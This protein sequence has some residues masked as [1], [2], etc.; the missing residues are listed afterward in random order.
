[1]KIIFIGFRL[2]PGLKEA[3][4]NKTFF[5]SRQLIKDKNKVIIITNGDKDKH[6]NFKG[7]KIHVCGCGTRNSVFWKNRNQFIEFATQILIKEQPDII[8]DVFGML[9]TSTITQKIIKKSKLK[10]TS[11]VRTIGAHGFA[12]K[13]FGR[14]PE[15]ILNKGFVQEYLPSLIFDNRLI[16]QLIAKKY[17]NII[18]LSNH[19]AKEFKHKSKLEI[20]NSIEL[21]S[22]L[23]YKK[24]NNNKIRKF[25]KENKLENKDIILYLGHL[26]FQKG[27]KYIIK[28]LPSILK[29]NKNAVVIFA[30]SGLG[31]D[32]SKYIKMFR[33][34][35]VPSEKVKIIEKVDPRLAFSASKIFILPLSFQ[36]GTQAQPDSLIEALACGCVP[37]VSGIGS[38]PE[39]VKNKKNGLLIKPFSSEEI[40][41]SV[42]VLLSNDKFYKKLQNN[43]KKGLERFDWKKNFPKHKKNYYDLLS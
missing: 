33:R 43:T 26:K 14:L 40:S 24:K 27:V 20:N 16:R 5:I 3:I 9:G 10:R 25:L 4:R 22:F 37:I 12:T 29:K 19:I 31:E 41:E 32:K 6:V 13:D 23:D 30:L 7:I 2:E 11:T 21:D 34:M 15:A 17:D 39:V 38:I 28:A 42:F 36:W 35:K 18:C 1:M 8:H